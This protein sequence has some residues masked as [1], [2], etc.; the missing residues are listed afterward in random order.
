MN[1]WSAALASLYQSADFPN[2]FFF[3]WGQLK[4]SC[5]FSFLSFNC[6]SQIPPHPTEPK[7]K[8]S[9]NII[10]I[11]IILITMIRMIIRLERKKIKKKKKE[12][13]RNIEKETLMRKKSGHIRSE[14]YFLKFYYISFRKR[15][16]AQRDI[17]KVQRSWLVLVAER[18][19][20]SVTGIKRMTWKEEEEEEFLGG[21]RHLEQHKF[22]VYEKLLIRQVLEDYRYLFPFSKGP[23][24]FISQKRLEKPCGILSRTGT[25]K[26]IEKEDF[27]LFLDLLWSIF[28]IDIQEK[29]RDL[30][31]LKT[32]IVGPRFC[33]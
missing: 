22:G 27:L 30:K 28:L 17:H 12:T 23:P 2:S 9:R 7:K 20:A 5:R 13:R 33:G 29:P 10:M 16:E 4:I 18:F 6:E 3:Q 21:H 15:W 31:Y 26:S 1:F 11:I 19:L 25:W 14:F 24:F 32:P 8:S